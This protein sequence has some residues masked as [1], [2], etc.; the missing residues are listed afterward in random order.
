MGGK[1]LPAR[2]LSHGLSP[3]FHPRIAT[4]SSPAAVSPPLPR[5]GAF[6]EADWRVLDSYWHSHRPE[7]RRDGCAL[8]G[9]AFATSAWSVI[10]FRRGSRG[11]DGWSFS[12][13]PHRSRPERRAS[14]PACYATTTS[15]NRS[16]LSWITT[17]GSSRRTALSLSLNTLRICRSISRG[18]VHIRTDKTSIASCRNSGVSASAATSLLNN[19]LAV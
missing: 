1:S 16:N 6:S 10:P 7:L 17:S 3:L 5:D 14:S 15:T 18:E 8:R 19:F 11:T 12:I 2:K 9:E 4:G 13:P